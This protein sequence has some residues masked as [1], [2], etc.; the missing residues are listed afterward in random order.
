[1]KMSNIPRRISVALTVLATCFACSSAATAQ[2]TDLIRRAVTMTQ[3][4]G[5]LFQNLGTNSAANIQAI[6]L[7]YADQVSAAV[8]TGNQ[9][10]INKLI[11]QFQQSAAKVTRAGLMEGMDN[12]AEMTEKMDTLIGAAS[13]PETVAQLQLYRG[14]LVSAHDTARVQIRTAFNSA[15]DAVANAANGN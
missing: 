14:I 7:S 1:M 12:I 13:K 2:D 6:G 15:R 3:S 5:P 8:A 9:T 4:G 10:R 11:R